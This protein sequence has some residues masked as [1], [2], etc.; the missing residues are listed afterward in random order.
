[1]DPAAEVHGLA[2]VFDAKDTTG[3]RPKARGERRRGH[4]EGIEREERGA[5]V[6]NRLASRDDAAAAP[7][8]TARGTPLL[9][10]EGGRECSG[11]NAC[12]GC[13]FNR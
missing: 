7:E 10:G 12:A 1:M 2:N 4:Y 6:A 5:R 11:I 3:M 8:R 9:D 13:A